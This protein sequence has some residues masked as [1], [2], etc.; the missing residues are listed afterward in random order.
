M[1]NQIAEL[2]VAREGLR[3]LV[4]FID[5]E[6]TARMGAGAVIA[7]TSGR[8][9]RI[10][11]PIDIRL[12]KSVAVAEVKLAQSGRRRLERM[13]GDGLAVL[14]RNQLFTW[15]RAAMNGSFVTCSQRILGVQ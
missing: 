2:F 11:V 12:R 9:R 3:V 15:S 8:V 7:G 6:I 13:A 10:V 5:D 4:P 14:R 1:A